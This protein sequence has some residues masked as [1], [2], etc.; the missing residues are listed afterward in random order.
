[1]SFSKDEGW[2]LREYTFSCTNA[3]RATGSAEMEVSVILAQSTAT[4]ATTGSSLLYCTVPWKPLKMEASYVARSSSERSDVLPHG[5]RAAGIAGS[6]PSGLVLTISWR[7]ACVASF[8]ALKH[9]AEPPIAGLLKADPT[10]CAYCSKLYSAKYGGLLD[11]APARLA[12]YF[13]LS[14]PERAP[15]YEPPKL[16]HLERAAAALRRSGGVLFT[17]SA[18]GERLRT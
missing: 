13:S 7:S 4:V 16:T 15:G 3:S 14:Q 5:R 12:G 6:A 9:A 11:T 18:T 10:T 1:M 8:T 17:S 2:H